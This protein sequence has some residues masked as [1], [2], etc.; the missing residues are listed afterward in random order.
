[1]LPRVTRGTSWARRGPSRSVRPPAARSATILL[2]YY[3]HVAF[4][5]LKEILV[6]HE[7]LHAGNVDEILERGNHTVKEYKRLTFKGGD[8]LD[9]SGS[10]KTWQVAKQRKRADGVAS[11]LCDEATVR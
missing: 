9:A 2:I 7:H 1:M 5:H 4:A 11:E 10:R 6:K 3:S 8:A